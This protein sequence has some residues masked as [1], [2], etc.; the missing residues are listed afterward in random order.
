V[1]E[2]G[3]LRLYRFEHAGRDRPDTL[4]GMSTTMTVPVERRRQGFLL[5][6]LTGTAV[7]AGLALWL[8][9]RAAADE[10]GRKGR[11]VRDD[12]AGAVA[13]GAHEVELGAHGIARGAHEVERLATAARGDRT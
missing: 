6:L 1:G 12:V 13:R 8:V 3:P 11:K 2:D 9:P 10:L 5:G 4:G 7:G